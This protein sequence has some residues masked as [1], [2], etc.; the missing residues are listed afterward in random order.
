MIENINRTGVQKSRSLSIKIDATDEKGFNI[1]ISGST[2]VLVN[3]CYELSYEEFIEV[4]QLLKALHL[5]DEKNLNESLTKFLSLKNDITGTYSTT[6]TLHKE[7]S[8]LLTFMHCR[9]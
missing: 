4:K 2:D 1:K 8:S 9:F 6:V 3:D 5:D 7:F